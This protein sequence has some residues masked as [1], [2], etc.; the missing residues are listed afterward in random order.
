MTGIGLKVLSVS[1]FLSMSTLLKAAGDV[2]P[3]ELVFFRS[4][5]AILP[6]VLFLS[7]RGELRSGL[8][9]EALPGH[10]W[11]GIVGTM[12]MACGF[13]ALTKLPLPEAV[14]LN[15]AT[16]LIIVVLSALFFGETIRLY[17]W[18]AV[19]VGFVGVV[20]M[21]W[22]RLTLFSDGTSL[23]SDASIGVLAALLGCC[24]AAGAMLLVRRLVRTERSAT[25][26]LY[27]SITS[28]VLGLCTLPFGWI[29]PTPQ[30]AV[31][32]ILA[33]IAGGI[34]QILLTESYRYAEMSVIAPFEYS[35]MI[36]SI[37]VGFL[38]FRDVPTVEMLIGGAIVVGAGL[39]IIWR[40]SRLGLD[41]A[42]ARQVTPP[43]G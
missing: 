5:F 21:V 15:Y 37:P 27:F 31:L 17:R 30:Q 23:A 20:V 41:R 13:L 38:L 1:V 39:F 42:A 43:Q 8:K 14:T 24:F 36:L 33:G 2:P 22:P 19:V 10:V 25:I 18:S 26:V 4:L 28:T 12:G 35:S 32:L 7:V 3:G 9:T 6:I 34:G 16:P 11:R 40:E 29:M